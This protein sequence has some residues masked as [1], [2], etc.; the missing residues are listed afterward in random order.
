MSATV[1]FT[2]DRLALDA[3]EEALWGL[4]AHAVTISDAAD[5]P[6]LEPGPGEAPMWEQAVVDALLPED[7]DP[8]AV[9]TALAEGG[10]DEIEFVDVAEREWERAWMDR[11]EPMRF[12]SGIWICPWHIEPEPEWPLVVRLDPGLAFGTGTHATTAL[13]L[14]WIDAHDPTGRK[15]VDYG[16]GS[17][18]L[19]IAAALKGARDVIA[20]DHD[21]QALDATR[22][23]AE[24]NGVAD[25]IRAIAPAE[26][27]ELEADIVL[28]N[29]LAGP[30]ADMAERIA[31]L[32]APG[33]WLVLSGILES[34][35]DQ[36]DAAYRPLLRPAGETHRDGWLRLDYRAEPGAGP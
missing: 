13:C 30:L 26:C 7:I 17:G 19:A 27:G 1:R 25:R 2:I 16:C 11:F 12:G 22:D 15:V 18:V 21:P 9:R 23:N 31:G 35:F 10:I 32:V 4:G 36:V 28:A 33:G 24:R 3:A 29:I 5:Q 14:E 20:V 6:L 34:Q 8:A